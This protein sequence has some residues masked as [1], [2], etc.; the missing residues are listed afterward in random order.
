MLNRGTDLCFDVDEDY[1][2][3]LILNVYWQRPSLFNFATPSYAYGYLNPCI[4][5]E[6]PFRPYQSVEPPLVVPGTTGRLGLDFTLN[7]EPPTIRFYPSTPQ[8]QTFELAGEATLGVPRLD[9][10]QPAAPLPEYAPPYNNDTPTPPIHPLPTDPT[11]PPTCWRF[12]FAVVGMVRHRNDGQAVLWL[13][14][15]SISIY[16]I[17]PPELRGILET[18]LLASLRYG[19]LPRLKVPVPAVTLHVGELMDLQVALA[20]PGAALP[21]NPEIDN[22]RLA[23]FFAV[24]ATP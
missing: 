20:P 15:Q 12:S 10:T 2:N 7:I 21:H 4:G 11:L 22:Q 13:E 6:F 5:L 24:S 3:T 1:F 9:T 18:D 8:P 23:V 19:L 17:D 14:A 16:G